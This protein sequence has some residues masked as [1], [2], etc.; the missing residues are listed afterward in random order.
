MKY[1]ELHSLVDK[2]KTMVLKELD[3][4]YY[5]SSS[6]RRYT[7]EYVQDKINDGGWH[8]VKEISEEQFYEDVERLIKFMYQG[9]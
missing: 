7:R 3:D 5:L 8:F 4:K 1:F 6:N 9:E 2:F